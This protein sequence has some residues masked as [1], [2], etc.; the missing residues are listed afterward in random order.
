MV[1]LSLSLFG[2]FEAR[3]PSGEMLRISGKKEQAL[4]A[5]LALC[6][7]QPKT[8][9]KIAALLWS[10]RGNAH[11]R[12]SLRQALVALRRDLAD[13]AVKTLVIDGDLLAVDLTRL[14]I[15]AIAAERL[16]AVD[17]ADDLRELLRLYRG[18][19]LDGFAIPDTAFEEW[20]GGERSRYREAVIAAIHRGLANFAGEE[21]IEIALR[22][23]ALDPLREASHYALMRAYAAQGQSDLALRQYQLC[24]DMLRRELDVEPNAELRAL[25]DAIASGAH[26]RDSALNLSPVTDRSAVMAS[27]LIRPNSQRPA[28]AVLPF[29]NLSDDMAQQYF[30][31]GITEDII[32]E[33]ARFSSLLVIARNSSF[34]YRGRDVD[35]KQVGRELG[36][37]YVVEGSVRRVGEQLRVTA[38][39]VDTKSGGHIWAQR[40][41]RKIDDLFS[42]QDELVRAVVATTENRIIDTEAEL[43]ARQPPN[44]W[45]AHDYYLQARKQM[46]EYWGYQKA[47]KPLLQAI[48]LDP[49]MAEAYAKLTHVWISKFWFSL[50]DRCVQRAAEYARKALSLNPRLSDSHNAMSIAYAFQ[51]QMDQAILHA[52]RAVELNPNDVHA[53]VD[54]AQWLIYSGKCVEGLAELDLLLKREPIPPVW[55]WDSRASGLFPLKRYQEVID[56]YSM[57]HRHQ[58]W[59]LAYIAASLAFLDRADEA[60]RYRNLLLAASPDMTIAQMLRIERHQTAAAKAHFAE[61]LRKAGV[62]E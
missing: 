16:L 14:D 60:T 45:A 42:T 19:L 18:D 22:L 10:D 6:G 50:D 17:R 55:Y 24:R 27:S 56:A 4:L 2:G 46:N 35:V 52:A 51:D 21:A 39:L 9:D 23:L 40:Y 34:Q 44:S 25:R 20:L 59:E 26:Q 7:G 41:D 30:S 62:P 48:E 58:P 1:L 54:F 13:V 61:G 32:T 28:I 37:Q 29:S 8:R 47:E 5:Y 38:Q 31:D 12:N 33:L 11:A 43:A 3:L 36:V 49:T 53:T 57:V 15:D